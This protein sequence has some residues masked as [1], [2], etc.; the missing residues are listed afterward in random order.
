MPSRFSSKTPG[1][2]SRGPDQENFDDLMG[3]LTRIERYLQALV[4]MA[5]EREIDR[6]SRKSPR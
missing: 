5:E 3:A 2:G 1:S 4:L 6:T